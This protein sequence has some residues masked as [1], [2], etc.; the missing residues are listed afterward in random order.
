MRDT[1]DSIVILELYS[2]EKNFS[3]ASD[4]LISNNL[5]D[6]NCV[7]I[8]GFFLPRLTAPLQM[9]IKFGNHKKSKGQTKSV[10]VGILIKIFR[11]RLF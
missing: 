4:S 10:S 8:K 7:A 3:R 11:E 1:I 2:P 9:L 6:I 5:F